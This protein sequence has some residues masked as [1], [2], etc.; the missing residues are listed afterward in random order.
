MQSG[1][2]DTEDACCGDAASSDADPCNGD[3]DCQMET[4]MLLVRSDAGSMFSQEVSDLASL[5]C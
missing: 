1:C 5:H 2:C 4:W 3:T